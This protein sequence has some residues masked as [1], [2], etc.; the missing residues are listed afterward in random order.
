MAKAKR[1]ASS[2]SLM[3][4]LRAVSASHSRKAATQQEEKVT[5]KV[6]IKHVKA[7][8]QPIV[9][10]VQ[11]AHKGL[12]DML[13]PLK[14]ERPETL[15]AVKEEFDEQISAWLKSEHRN[16]NKQSV[17]NM[18]SDIMAAIGCYAKYAGMTKEQQHKYNKSEKAASTYHAYIALCRK[19]KRGK[20]SKAETKRGALSA[21]ERLIAGAWKRKKGEA[22]ERARNYLRFAPTENLMALVDFAESLIAAR[23]KGNVLRI[24]GYMKAQAAEQQQVKAKKAA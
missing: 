4:N 5:F 7:L 10:H 22:M 12:R 1:V 17:Y 2:K 15:E 9:A 6:N 21:A 16:I 3:A 11:H 14:G 20:T 24:D 23:K 8:V 19:V 18:R 13:L